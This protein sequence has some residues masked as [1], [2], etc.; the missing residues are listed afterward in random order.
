MCFLLL[1]CV[2]LVMKTRSVPLSLPHSLTRSLFMYLERVFL[3][4]VVSALVLASI[5]G[6]LAQNKLFGL[7]GVRMH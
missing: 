7:Q 6:R 3:L 1:Y 2:I 4:S 5:F